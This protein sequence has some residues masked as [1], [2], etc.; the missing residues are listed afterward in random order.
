MK[1]VKDPIGK[2][3]HDFPACST[4]PHLCYH[5][6]LKKGIY[7]TKCADDDCSLYAV[8]NGVQDAEWE[9]CLEGVYRL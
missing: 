3:T 9:L 6:P 4:V 2:R 8:N 7:G 5:V 1:N